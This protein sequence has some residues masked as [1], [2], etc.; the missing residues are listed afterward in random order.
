MAGSGDDSGFE[1]WLAENG[2]TL[3]DGS[4]SS[5]V[6]R[7]RGSAYVDGVSGSR[8]PGVP[9]E[10]DVLTDATVRLATVEGLLAPLFRRPEPAIFAV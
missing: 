6:L 8:F 4:L 9:T 3:H 7:Q 1:A 2:H 10:G 5:A